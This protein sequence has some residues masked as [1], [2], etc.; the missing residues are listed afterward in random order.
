[1]YILRGFDTK[2]MI[3]C[4]IYFIKMFFSTKAISEFFKLFYLNLNLEQY[5]RKKLHFN[6]KNFFL[7]LYKFSFKISTSK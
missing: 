6:S 2:F 3:I 1:M 5:V 4:F 7:I